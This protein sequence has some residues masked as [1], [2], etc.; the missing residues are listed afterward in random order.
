MQYL[1][2]LII[3]NAASLLYYFF[4]KGVQMESIWKRSTVIGF[5][6][7]NF[8]G[9]ST[10]IKYVKEAIEGY[11]EKNE[12][13]V[14]VE[15]IKPSLTD[16]DTLT[17]LGLI[18]PGKVIDGEIGKVI[19]IAS[20]YA[21]IYRKTI[22]EIK[23]KEIENNSKD[24][25]HYSIYLFDRTPIATYA[26][27]I[28]NF[29][30]GNSDN[31]DYEKFI[32]KIDGFSRQYYDLI[33][34]A[35]MSMYNNE[36]SKSVYFDNIFILESSYENMLKFKEM[37][38]EGRDKEYEGIIYE[39][40]KFLKI[41]G[42][43]YDKF[44]TSAVGL[45]TS[46]YGFNVASSNIITLDTTSKDPKDIVSSIVLS[47]MKSL[48]SNIDS[49]EKTDEEEPVDTT[50]PQTS[51]SNES[52]SVLLEDNVENK[53]DN[54]EIEDKKEEPEE[55]EEN[56][57]E[58]TSEV[59]ESTGS[60]DYVNMPEM[61]L[62]I[63]KEDGSVEEIKIEK[64]ST[65]IPSQSYKLPIILEPRR[66]TEEFTNT[67]MVSRKISSAFKEDIPMDSKLIYENGEAVDDYISF[68]LA[69]VDGDVTP[70]LETFII[71]YEKTGKPVTKQVTIKY[72]EE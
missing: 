17:R 65:H 71:K 59:N 11:A 13:N 42:D 22:E 15:V 63:P 6:G 41:L 3:V 16:L 64:P 51:N 40:D 9:K 35:I 12:F 33:V 56:S 24:D 45:S 31:I 68:K 70:G 47:I 25:P 46:L 19:E 69:P 52:N 23:I 62:V 57:Q 28:A 38:A 27:S 43:V 49:N 48:K 67:I 26:Y 4:V 37:S 10:F 20:Y 29:I 5:D 14:K 72:V 36:P 21:G 44:L 7:P 60:G 53:E 18:G 61:Y 2:I 8:T 58:N 50:E 32:H 39:D 1:T 66:Y 54:E 34:N 30:I 55:V